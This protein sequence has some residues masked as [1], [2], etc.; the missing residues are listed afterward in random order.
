M[1]SMLKSIVPVCYIHVDICV[2]VM[3]VTGKGQE[4]KTRCW[5]TMPNTGVT[6]EKAENCA[7][8][9]TGKSKT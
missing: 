3:D 9:L 7:L 6:Y 1:T 2:T 5:V 8:N 4:Q